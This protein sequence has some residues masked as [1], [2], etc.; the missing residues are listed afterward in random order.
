MKAYF[1]DVKKSSKKNNFQV[2]KTE[3]KK[4][5]EEIMQASEQAQQETKN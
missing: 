3:T 1:D 2:Q 4:K 5:I